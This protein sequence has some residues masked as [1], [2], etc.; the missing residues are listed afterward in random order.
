MQLSDFIRGFHNHPII[1]LGTG[2][3]V[4]YSNISY[5]WE[6]L[7]K[8][9]A[10]DFT[11][12]DEYFLDLK[13]EHMKPN[14][15]CNY[16][17]IA[18]C[19]EKDF[20][21]E[22]KKDRNGKFKNINDLFYKNMEDGINI[23][24]FKL[25]IAELLKNVERNEQTRIEINELI[26]A[27][28]NIGSI[29]TTNYDQL[30]ENI[31]GFTPLIGND[32]LLSN[33]YGSIYKI[34]GCITRPDKIIIT[35]EDYQEFEIRY[36]LI[37]AQLL[38]FFI[39]NPIIF[40]GYSIT[41]KNIKDILKTIFSYVDFNSELAERIRANF[42]L[43]E[44]EKGNTNTDV[45]E[46]DIDIENFKTIR[47]NKLKTDNYIALYKELSTLIL[48][49]S[50]MDVRKV[51][52]IMHEIYAGGDIK[53]SI[54]ED[55]ESL[56]NSDKVL[57]IGSEKTI[58]YEFQTISEMIANYF[59][60]IEESNDQ[61]L[62]TLN[63]Q[64]IQASQFFPIFGFSKICNDITK[65]EKLKKQQRTKIENVIASVPKVCINQHRTVQEILDDV[66][67]SQT[68]KNSA[69]IYALMDG[70]LELDNIEL[71]LRACSDKK[72]T[73]YRKLLCAFDLKKYGE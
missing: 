8:K 60:I 19:M 7:L 32:I 11:S 45:V 40:I 17:E 43:V 14:G 5:T 66:R 73:D 20:N 42:L 1:F 70:S 31:F 12:S 37:R 52:N 62:L 53:V 26:K 39:H 46:H 25:Y 33:P 9:I 71:Y 48:P 50:A 65:S 35:E 51:Q 2:F 64:Q 67:I 56:K 21:C 15:E 47:I 38:S 30:A 63:K 34:H 55:L 57:V 10:F 29:I 22:L 24:R 68:Y 16:A 36:E 28:K 69:I 41:D 49:I 72:S 59:Q 6:G 4:R 23:S 44:Y 18:S 61:L 3:S 54:T 58:K 13:S 27:K